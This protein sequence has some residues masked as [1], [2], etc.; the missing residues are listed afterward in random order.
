[1]RAL[2]IR[3]GEGVG[4]AWGQEPKA[5]AGGARPDVK[6]SPS[7]CHRPGGPQAEDFLPRA[8]HRTQGPRG[9]GRWRAPLGSCPPHRL[10]CPHSLPRANPWGLSSKGQTIQPETREL[11]LPQLR[12]EERSVLTHPPLTKWDLADTALLTHPHLWLGVWMPPGER[13]HRAPLRGWRL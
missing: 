5:N 13:S 10:S 3:T 2:G 1:M 9:A 8:P 4:A 7:V 6:D 11:L 12:L